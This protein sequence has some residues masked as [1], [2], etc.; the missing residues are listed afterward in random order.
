MARSPRTPEGAGERDC[1]RARVI[2]L[3]ARL[4]EW[5]TFTVGADA[6]RLGQAID[7][8][9]Q[10][11][12]HVGLDPSSLSLGAYIDIAVHPD[13]EVARDLVRGVVGI[14]AHFLGMRGAPTEL[15]GAEDR[16]VVEG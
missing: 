15:L 7:T 2:E 16:E 6:G 9:R 14:H 5:V 3:G 8:A 1:Q 12:R 4:G 11:R 10:A 13:L